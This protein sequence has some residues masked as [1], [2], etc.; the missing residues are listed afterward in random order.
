MRTSTSMATCP[1]INTIVC[2]TCILA[3]GHVDIITM[4]CKHVLSF[5]EVGIIHEKRELKEQ[6]L[7]IESRKIK[8]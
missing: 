8:V 5:L 1:T 2:I 7:R 4:Q 3:V 6:V